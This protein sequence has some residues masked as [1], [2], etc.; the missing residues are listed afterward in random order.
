MYSSAPE[1]ASESLP[2]KI[3]RDTFKQRVLRVQILPGQE[4]AGQMNEPEP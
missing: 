4:A 3:L 1:S 2:D